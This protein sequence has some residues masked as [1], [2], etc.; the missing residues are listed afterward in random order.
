MEKKVKLEERFCTICYGDV[1]GEV[2]VCPRAD[3]WMCAA[4][5]QDPDFNMKCPVCKTPMNLLKPQE[6]DLLNDKPELNEDKCIM[7]QLMRMPDITLEQ[8]NQ[9]FTRSIWADRF[10]YTEDFEEAQEAALRSDR[11]WAFFTHHVELAYQKERRETLSNL[12]EVHYGWTILTAST[13]FWRWILPLMG[14][15]ML[16][17]LNRAHDVLFMQPFKRME[18]ACCEI[19]A[20]YMKEQGY[21]VPNESYGVVGMRRNWLSFSLPVALELCDLLQLELDYVDFLH[22][23]LDLHET[24]AIQ[25]YRDHF[26]TKTQLLWTAFT[27]YV[28]SVLCW[29]DRTASFIEEALKLKPPGWT[30]QGKADHPWLRSLSSFIVVQ[31]NEIKEYCLREWQAQGAAAASNPVTACQSYIDGQLM[32]SG[33]LIRDEKRECLHIV[34]FETKELRVYELDRELHWDEDYEVA[35][36]ALRRGRIKPEAGLRMSFASAV[37]MFF[38]E[39]PF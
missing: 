22:C 24:V 14:K 20:Q 1:S 28:N 36:K 10:C 15:E 23:S 3:H 37:Y 6:H 4:H 25:Y 9:W 32:F 5:M 12:C 38:D 27:P 34:R 18:I 39:K 26:P 33:N 16:M 7:L 11:N 21:K 19:I 30:F 35:K 29:K 17:I 13:R 31:G 8:M 2:V